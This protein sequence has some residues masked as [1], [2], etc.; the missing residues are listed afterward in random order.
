MSSQSNNTRSTDGAV[1]LS[2]SQYAARRKR[3]F[4]FLTRV[5]AIGADVDLDIPAIVVMGW[6]SAGKS[7]LI[8]AISGITLPR[9]SGTCTRVSLR[10]TNATDS[11]TREIPFGGIITEKSD[12]TERIRRAQKAIL[13]PSV[14][15]DNF[16]SRTESDFEE[17]DISFSSDCIVLHI[18]G[19][20]I[21]DLNFID[22][23]GLFVGGED[24]EINLIRDL[25]ISYIRRPSCIILL[26]VTCESVTWERAREAESAFFSQT[27]PWSMLNGE[28]KQRLGTGNLTR[29]LSEK[30]CDLIAE[31]LPAIQQELKKLIER[32][33]IELHDLPSPPSS[34]PLRE[35]LRLITDLTRA[36]EKQVEGV[37]GSE[38]LLQQIR[39][40]QEEFRTVIRTTAP[41][42]VP[43]YRG[44]LEYSEPR[45]MLMSTSVDWESYQRLLFL[46]GE[47]DYAEIGLDNG[48]EL[49][50][51]DVL[52]TAQWYTIL[53]IL[54]STFTFALLTTT[55][56]SRAVTRELP[57]NYPFIVQRGYIIDTVSKW[58]DPAKT[59]LDFT[60]K[61]LKEVTSS[62][63]DAHFERYAHG[64][65][66]QRV[67]N[68]VMMHLDQ[69]TQET[70]SLIKFLL[71]GEKEPS[72]RH[73]HYFKDYRRKFF[74]F[75][76]GIYNSS[77]NS[78]FIERL[79]S[80]GYGYESSEFGDALEIVISN[81][82]KIGFHNVQPLELAVLRA[83]EDS[84]DAIKIMADV[85]AYFQVAYKRFV[86]NVPKAIDEQ[87]VLGIARGLQDALATGLGLDSHDAHER[88]AKLLAEP[89]RIA[90]K[91]EKLVARQKRLLAAQD[92]L[93]DAFENTQVP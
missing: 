72:T 52:E 10:L 36:V 54:H 47:E 9:A 23:P 85:R 17:S 42:F 63:V 57:N 15:P 49:F 70:S 11:S 55:F 50:I 91:R 48:M 93:L 76:K 78:N 31:R 40:Q 77:S 56:Q 27:A 66:K 21:T 25:A 82:R 43:K 80:T 5:R 41:C 12:V 28:S 81:L 6:Q 26:T 18:S 19:P 84:D 65:L 87:L 45:E 4:E 35:I 71:E 64:N 58:D 62:V 83:S 37:P 61:K 8:E 3:M 73:T 46:E 14:S 32:T 92:E 69:S 90:E 20:D 29:H 24:T 44:V 67:L 7:S 22:L 51:D 74:A 79:R 33:N 53:N 68:I 34:E 38:G 86:D 13:S 1:G 89:P 59:L 75:Y 39:P 60:V 30:L 2:D 16:L 88:C